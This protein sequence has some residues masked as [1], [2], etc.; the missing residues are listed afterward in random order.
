M[1][2]LDLKSRILSGERIPLE[3][4]RAFILAA[5]SDL[6]TERKKRNSGE[7]PKDVDFF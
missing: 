3:E 1:H 4:L 2:N 5:E 7:K 6:T